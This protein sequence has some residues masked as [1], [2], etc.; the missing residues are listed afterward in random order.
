MP[1]TYCA[2][3]RTNWAALK[4]TEIDENF[5]TH[6][7]CPKC[8]SNLFLEDTKEGKTLTA[9]KPFEYPPNILQSGNFPPV[10]QNSKEDIERNTGF[11]KRKRNQTLNY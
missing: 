3:C 8:E 7:I 4:E 5:E 11:E 2:R 1:K 10:P 9:Y 6:H